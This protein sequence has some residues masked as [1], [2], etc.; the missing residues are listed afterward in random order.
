MC[1]KLNIAEEFTTTPGIRY[2][3]DSD[4][5]GEEFREVLL[6]P[7]YLRAIRENKRLYIDIDGGYGY[8]TSF[9]EEAFGGLVR[10]EGVDANKLLSILEIKS[11]DEQEWIEKIKGYIKDA[12]KK[13]R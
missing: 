11:E 9:L 1:I 8:A 7:A 12:N 2:R 13:K 4:Y 6:Y 10:V 3:K 5:S